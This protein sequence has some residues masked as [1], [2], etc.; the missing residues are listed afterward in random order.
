LA[1]WKGWS[2][3]YF[4]PFGAKTAAEI[5]KDSV[6]RLTSAAPVHR[7]PGWRKDAT[8]VALFRR[9]TDATPRPLPNSTNEREADSLEIG[10]LISR[11][12]TC[13]LNKQV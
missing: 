7:H 10:D 13:F 8:R 3:A 11:P 2:A 4:R 1:S 12:L 6:L 5:V 9:V